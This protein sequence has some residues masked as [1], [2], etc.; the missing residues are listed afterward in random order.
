VTHPPLHAT[1]GLSR[2]DLLATGHAIIASHAKGR[3][4]A[5]MTT[6]GVYG[7]RR[8]AADEWVCIQV[9][10]VPELVERAYREIHHLAIGIIFAMTGSVEIHQAP[11]P[12]VDCALH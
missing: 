10:E 7:W 12:Q 9:R 6:F 4:I 11:M 1:F 2:A 5:T 3:F 8:V